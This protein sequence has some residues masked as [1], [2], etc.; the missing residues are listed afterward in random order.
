MT[1]DEHLKWAKE[2]VRTMQQELE[3]MDISSRDVET[4]SKEHTDLV[5]QGEA[6]A[7][8]QVAA[9]F[10]VRIREKNEE[11]RRL[12][13][14]REDATSELNV[15]NRQADFRAKLDM[16]R[17]AAEQKTEEASKESHQAVVDVDDLDVI[18]SPE[19]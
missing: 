16:K 8:A 17:R 15:L 10:D 5:E 3:G 1:R 2:R 9:N 13:E 19:K 4:A 7:S 6:M 14:Q 12:D 11:I 18:A